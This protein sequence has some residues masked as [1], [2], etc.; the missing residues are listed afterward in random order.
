MA[1]DTL[2]PLLRGVLWGA[3]LFG[4]ASFPA[5]AQRVTE[6]TALSIPRPTTGGVPGLPQVLAP[7]DAARLRRIF[8]L[9]ARGDHAAATRE[10]GLVEDR[11][12]MGHVQADRWLRPSGNPQASEVQAWLAQHADHPDAR[13]LHDLLGTLLPKGAALPAPPTQ[14]EPLAP[15]ASLAPE[16]TEPGPITRNPLLD[17]TVR[18]RVRE[19][20]LSSALSLIARTPGMRPDY[21]AL[22]KGEIALQLL[23]MGRDEEAMRI[24]SEVARSGR[25]RGNGAYAA[26]LAAWQLERYD[27]ALPY[28]ERAA[29]NDAAAPALRSAAAFWTARAAVRARKPQLYVSWMMQAAQEPRTFYGLVARRALGLSAGF[30]WDSELAG[31]QEAAA[32]AELAGGWRALAL[33]QIGQ[34]ARAEAELRLLWDKAKSNPA[35][36]RSMLAVANAA[37]IQGLASQ[38]AAASQSADGRPR[39]YARFPLPRLLPQGGFRVDPALLY[40]IALQESRFNVGAVSPAGAR[41]LMQIM[42]AT[43]RFMTNDASIS[44]RLNDPATSLEL[45]QRYVHHLARLEVVEGNLIR[46]LAAYNAGP[47]NLARWLPVQGH[48]D[49]PFLFIEAI[50]I[51]ETR[52]YVQKVLANTWIYASRLG[53]PAPSL[54]QLAAGSFPKFSQPEDVVAMLRERG[55]TLH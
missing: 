16:D 35:L 42:P 54:D 20:N 43:A 32:V 18:D 36:T 19:G 49:D 10:Q 34:N 22:L 51:D 14:A 27:F 28:F 53:L 29:R 55:R 47:G 13:R 30:A 6:Q 48:R 45:A 12:L 11:R 26:G 23:R 1:R 17:R 25:D 37:G 21:A 46:L 31:E 38:L 24:G 2:R 15:D 3:A 7:S 52:A 44:G 5:A 9:Q 40:G 39:D 41:G 50:P 33:L 8:E 4:W